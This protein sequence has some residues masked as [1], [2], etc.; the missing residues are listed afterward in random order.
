MSRCL[1]NI[2]F[3]DGRSGFRA[4]R[5]HRKSASHHLGR[6][7][8]R[9]R[10]F[11]RSTLCQLLRRIVVFLFLRRKRRQQLFGALRALSNTSLNLSS[12]FFWKIKVHHFNYFR[13]D[14]FGILHKLCQRSIDSKRNSV[15]QALSDALF[16]VL[17]F[18]S[19]TTFN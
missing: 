16:S 2:L 9:H 3:F 19:D 17:L 14:P 15:R 8:E 5:N 13:H 6:S 1:A 7:M 11:M 12:S 10:Q 4:E 18:S